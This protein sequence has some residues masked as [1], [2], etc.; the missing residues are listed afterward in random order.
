MAA[1]VLVLW[2]AV[3]LSQ[4][5]FMSDLVLRLVS[6]GHG[7]LAGSRTTAS[8]ESAAGYFGWY[9]KKDSPV[10]MLAVAHELEPV[11]AQAI[12]ATMSDSVAAP[13]SAAIDMFISCAKLPS[14]MLVRKGLDP[15]IEA[16][17]NPAVVRRC[18]CR[19]TQRS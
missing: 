3:G 12:S 13:S 2:H 5:R 9:V 1:V 7:T 18:R 17:K 14:K 19:L 16:A 4:H 8:R 6:G 15:F 10:S 11:L